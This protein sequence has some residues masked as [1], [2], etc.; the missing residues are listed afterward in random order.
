MELFGPERCAP[1]RPTS[2][3]GT[4]V[5]RQ[6]RR[7]V[8][9]CHGERD[10]NRDCGAGPDDRWGSEPAGMVGIITVYGIITSGQLSSQPVV[11][12]A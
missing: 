9:H 5:P 4:R 10:A 8:L 3:L 6:L 7:R 1:R 11:E 2:L 12:V